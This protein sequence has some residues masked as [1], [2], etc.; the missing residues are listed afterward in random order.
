MIYSNLL[1]N[2]NHQTY[3]LKYGAKMKSLQKA[4]TDL[5]YGTTS[6]VKKNTNQHHFRVGILIYR[7][8]YT[9]RLEKRLS[10]AYQLSTLIINKD[11]S[12]WNGL[13]F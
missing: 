10:S 3:I 12:Q 5:I 9:V 7:S 6:A 2:K 11:S 1:E 4:V 8:L 13:I